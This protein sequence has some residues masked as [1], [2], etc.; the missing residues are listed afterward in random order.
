MKK[1]DLLSISPIDGRYSNL[2]KDISLIFSE[3]NLIKQRVRVE[4]EWFKFLAEANDVSTLPPISKKNESTLNQIV[5]D[6]SLKDAKIDAE[7]P[8]ARAANLRTINSGVD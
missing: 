1:D 3:Y 4:I 8:L 2:C 6:F 5:S 7:G